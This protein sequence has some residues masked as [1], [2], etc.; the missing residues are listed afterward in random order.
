MRLIDIRTAVETIRG[1]PVSIES[2]ELVLAHGFSQKP[3]PL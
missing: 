1:R 2:R 3:G